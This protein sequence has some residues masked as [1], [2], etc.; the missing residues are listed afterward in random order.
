MSRFFDS[1]SGTIN[2]GSIH[3][4]DE[5]IAIINGLP[6]PP[7]VP[8]TAKDIYVRKCRLV[9]DGINCHFGRFHTEDLPELLRKTQGVSCLIGH[10]KET[11]GI[12]RFFDGAIEK[13]K[14][15]NIVTGELEE[16]NFIVPKIYWMKAHSHAEDLRV[17]IDGGIYHQASI[18]WYFE[19]PACGICGKDIRLC[20]HV[21]G[22]RYNRELC[23]F[24]YEEIGDVL[25]GSIV[26][27]GGHPGTGF[28]LN[29]SAKERSPDQEILFKL[30]SEGRIHKSDILPYLKNI[31]SGN[32]YV[33][34]DL[35]NQGWTET[36][37]DILTDK[38]AYE[39]V[40]ELL[41]P[42]LTD[43][44]VIHE[45]FPAPG[46]C[47][48][49][50]NK[51]VLEIESVP[52]PDGNDAERKV[53]TAVNER[54]A[55]QHEKTAV[56]CEVASS[57][58]ADETFPPKNTGI[59][60]KGEQMSFQIIEDDT[61]CVS[62]EKIFNAA[63]LEV[64]DEPCVVTPHYDGIPVIIAVDKSSKNSMDSAEEK[65]PVSI[66]IPK[67]FAAVENLAGKHLQDIALKLVQWDVGSCELS[68]ELLAYRGRSRI[69]LDCFA[70]NR[71]PPFEKLRFMVKICDCRNANTAELNLPERLEY[72]SRHIKDSD[73]VQ[74]IPYRIAADFRQ[75]KNEAQVIGT[76]EGVDITRES[77][78]FGASTCRTFF[79]K[80]LI[81]DVVVTGIEKK[82]NG[83][84]F[85]AGIKDKNAVVPI[86]ATHISQIKCDIG[87]VLRVEVD[88]V[89]CSGGMY[90]WQNPRVVGVQNRNTQPDSVEIVKRLFQALHEEITGDEIETERRENTNMAV[91]NDFE[92]QPGFLLEADTENPGRKLILNMRRNS[93][94]NDVFCIQKDDIRKLNMGY[95]CPGYWIP[96]GNAAGSGKNLCEKP[97][98]AAQ[99]KGEVVILE[100]GDFRRRITFAGNILH[101]VYQFRCVNK[102]NKNNWY[103]KKLRVTS[104]TA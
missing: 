74:V 89:D 99:D 23:F 102:D 9:G 88:S 51:S 25:E 84:V 87:S 22:K 71:I 26:Y 16:M 42:Y 69:E 64:D 54:K 20:E 7:P 78:K 30:A 35:A 13:H 36:S 52:Q 19:K 65:T 56:M 1:L 17:N 62:A 60:E 40:G 49:I 41:P 79:S 59:G 86:G 100:W 27:A 75:V 82:R 29:D 47:I 97:E 53:K 90:R 93:A 44:L 104:H 57:A 2:N 95:M 48:K 46:A 12:A 92:K 38:D 76:R 73:V 14:A 103:I 68:G 81:L 96:G 8:V 31:E 72:I 85:K 98:Q 50:N 21:P 18:S 83:I 77:A 45:F 101:G 39:R 33:I 58:G 3:A 4:A 80:R 37:I 24:W 91:Q 61:V 55:A 67:D 5:D 15:R 66:I 94:Y 10:R 6:N 32:I 63:Q 34:G 11:A 28:T 70:M 43:R